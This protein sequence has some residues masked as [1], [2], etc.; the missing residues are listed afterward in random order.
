MSKAGDGSGCGRW[1][2]SVSAAML[3]LPVIIESTYRLTKREIRLH[4]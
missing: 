1:L 3:A 4:E 2:P